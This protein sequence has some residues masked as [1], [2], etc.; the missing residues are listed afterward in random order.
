MCLQVPVGDLPAWFQKNLSG[1][2]G[3]ALR[4]NYDNLVRSRTFYDQEEDDG[5]S[6]LDTISLTQS[7]HMTAVGSR[8]RGGVLE[9]SY[10]SGLV[11]RVNL[12]G[13]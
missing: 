4:R 9:P 8:F 5:N 3:A 12:R 10:K 1:I 11:M 2:K 7:W 13:A 6:N